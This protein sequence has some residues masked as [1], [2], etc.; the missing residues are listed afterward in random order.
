MRIWVA[1]DNAKGV[2]WP[3][4]EAADRGDEEGMGLNTLPARRIANDM[5]VPE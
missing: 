4:T 5:F 2:L 1:L 3:E